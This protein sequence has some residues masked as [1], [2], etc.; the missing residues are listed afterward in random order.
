MEN[1]GATACELY[2]GAHN[3]C[4]GTAPGGLE[5]LGNETKD[6]FFNHASTAKKKKK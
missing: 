5:G 3:K 6:G 1:A 4:E 2:L